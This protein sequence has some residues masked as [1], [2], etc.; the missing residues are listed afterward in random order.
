MSRHALLFLLLAASA[1]AADA[2]TYL[3]QPDGSGDFATIEEAISAAADGD[4]IELADGTFSGPGNRDIDLLG[5][6][7]TIR[8][9]T[10]NAEACRIDCQ[11][12]ETAHHRAFHFHSGEGPESRLERV[13]ITNGYIGDGAA[14]YVESLAA[15]TLTG[16]IF[17]TNTALSGGGA[18]YCFGDVSVTNC[19]FYDN[20]AASRGGAVFCFHNQSIFQDCLFS[21]NCAINW[22]G[23]VSC[24][25]S[26][27]HL[28]DCTFLENTAY[29]SGAFSSDQ[30]SHPILL[31][32]TFLSNTATHS[33]GG[34]ASV[35]FASFTDCLFVGNASP[36]QGGAVWFSYPTSFT[37]CTFA[38][39]VAPEGAAI[40]VFYG[41]EGT[42]NACTLLGNEAPSTSAA[43][44]CKSSGS[45]IADNTIVASTT[46]GKGIRCEGSAPAD[47]TCCD[48]FGNE[49]GDWIGC[50]EG[51]LGVDGN[52]S[53]D[54]LFCWPD[55]TEAMDWSLHSNSPCAPPQSECGL[56]GAWGVGCGPTPAHSPTWGGL[57]ALFRED[58]D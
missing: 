25:A 55:P 30:W 4:V 48:V 13:T 41:G 50:L 43:V 26:L 20:L 45:V 22:G 31:R 8:S 28:V 12:S 54:P 32:C 39:N 19:H 21:R 23:A 40:Q 29:G 38:R 42:L 6:A 1:C 7:I 47:L 15:P 5:K 2:E 36:L 18:L 49:G 14:I 9:Q 11:G 34:A 57:K 35:E 56:M 3:V 33:A 10:G 24:V 16:C 46:G 44:H 53:E 51:Q 37:Q 17:R 52:I 58:T 27:P